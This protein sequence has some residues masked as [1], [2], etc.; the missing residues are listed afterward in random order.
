MPIRY[1]IPRPIT[2]ADDEP[3]AEALAS[4]RMKARTANLYKNET[5]NS[6]APAPGTGTETPS[7]VDAEKVAEIR[8]KLATASRWKT[9]R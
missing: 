8:M 6:T 2:R 4:A 9:V 5:T 1:D 7:G 3:D